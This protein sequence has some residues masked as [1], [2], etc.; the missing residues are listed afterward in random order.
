MDV[1]AAKAPTIRM[2]SLA[3]PG[4]N[5][6]GLTFFNPELAAKR[7]ELVKEVIPALTDVGVLLN[8]SNPVNE[9]VI[10]EMKLTAQ[11]LK[12]K[13]HQFHVRGPAE[14]ECAFAA[15]ATERLWSSTMRC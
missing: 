8:P 5:V 7:L 14:F 2:A 12:L 11:P 15:I 9:P 3:R 1:G 13:L 10:P 6:T 4:G